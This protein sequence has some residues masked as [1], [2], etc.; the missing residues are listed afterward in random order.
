MLK[1]ALRL[2]HH[3]PM[4]FLAGICASTKVPSQGSENWTESGPWALS[5]SKDCLNLS[6]DLEWFLV[7][8]QNLLWIFN[9]HSSLSRS[10]DFWILNL[11][12]KGQ[13]C[14]PFGISTCT[15]F[16]WT[17]DLDKS[18]LSCRLDEKHVDKSAS[19]P[20][21]LILKDI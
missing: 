14:L 1:T 13:E 9:I 18:S 21:A 15:D 3:E 10:T 16:S 19:S 7:F 8:K 5:I 20:P 4:T 17:Q 6:L 12:P 11:T 2:C